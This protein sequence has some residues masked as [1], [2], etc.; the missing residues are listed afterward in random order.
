MWNGL[1]S[2]SLV[3]RSVVSA[4]PTFGATRCTA[5]GESRCKPMNAR[6]RIGSE[7]DDQSPLG[8]GQPFAATDC[9]DEQHPGRYGLVTVTVALTLRPSS[10]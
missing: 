7:S 1:A 5:A 6:G 2:S 4:L 10:P 9:L 8:R 3:A